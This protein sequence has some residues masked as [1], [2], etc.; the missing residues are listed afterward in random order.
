MA[1]ARQKFQFFTYFQPGFQDLDELPGGC[2][3]GLDLLSV[4]T[5]CKLS[6]N[7]AAGTFELQTDLSSTAA[8]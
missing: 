3:G 7:A 2:L 5:N 1:T 8:F 6:D 4:I